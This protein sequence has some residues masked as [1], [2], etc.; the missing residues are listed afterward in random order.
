MRY[1]P[2]RPWLFG[3]GLAVAAASVITGY[4]IAPRLSALGINGFTAQYGIIGALGFAGFAFGVPLGLAISA[5]GA[6]DPARDSRSQRLRDA[7]F[8]LGVGA[9][10]VLVPLVAGRQPDALWFGAGGWLLLLLI[11]A[12]LWL[13]GARRAALSR[14]ERMAADLQGAGYVCFALAAW[15]LC[16]IAAMP[17]FALEPQRM[18]ALG[19]H[20]F[21]VG[22]TKTVMA[23]LL[24]GWLFSAWG[25][26]KELQR[27]SL[28]DSEVAPGLARRGK[29]S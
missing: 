23:L 6:L 7:V 22:Q 28:P 1:A 18:L 11:L 16:G 14:G 15:N 21:A 19:S 10:A 12:T 5:L 2:A 8:L 29:D 17:S 24:L 13:W 27:R 25:Y 9:L 26:H 20:A 4:A 3:I